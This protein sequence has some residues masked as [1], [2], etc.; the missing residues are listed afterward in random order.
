M[1]SPD[2]SVPEWKNRSR[3][4]LVVGILF[5]MMGLGLVAPILPLYAREFGVSR[6]A[7]SALIAGFA[8]ARLVFDIGGSVIMERAGI[9][10]VMI[11]G[12]ILL[13]VSSVV[14]AVAPNYTVL[15]VS[16]VVEGFGSAAFATGAQTLIV[17]NTPSDR[18]ARA[19]ATYQGGLL[20][21][22]AIGPI[23]GGFAAEWGDLTT[24][25]WLYAAVGLVAAAIATRVDRPS[26]TSCSSPSHCS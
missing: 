3:W 7:A 23:V 13:A 10:R 11:L 14:A 24:P 18:M 20:V 4:P 9:P 25:F 22:I 26:S 21:G 5:S 19:M 2:N 1:R 8:V 6:T 17:R 12:G 15:L 16:G